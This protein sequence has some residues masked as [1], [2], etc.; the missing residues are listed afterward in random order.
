M[1]P[2]HLHEHLSYC[3]ILYREENQELISQKTRA[4]F[5]EYNQI[6]K[7]SQQ[8]LIQIDYLYHN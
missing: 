6:K 7:S 8:Q 5:H 2:H 1:H 3:H 4:L